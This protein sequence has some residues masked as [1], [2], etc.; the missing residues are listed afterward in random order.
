MQITTIIAKIE[1]RTAQKIIVKKNTV[2][3]SKSKKQKNSIIINPTSSI[4]NKG[5][6]IL[7]Q[8]TTYPKSCPPNHLSPSNQNNLPQKDT[9]AF[10]TKWNLS[11][12]AQVVL[13]S[14]TEEE[15]SYIR[16]NF[17]PIKLK[18]IS[19]KLTRYSWKVKHLPRPLDAPIPAV[20]KTSFQCTPPPPYPQ[21]PKPPTPATRRGI[22]NYKNSCYF[23]SIIQM[24][25]DTPLGHAFKRCA[26]YYNTQKSLGDLH[27]RYSAW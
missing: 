1:V 25:V 16:R 22:K 9:D 7:P 20:P 17:A 21:P 15:Q 8:P 14:C 10:I 3:D 4:K 24:L 11:P 19:S 2:T 13:K 18:Q 26:A 23:V 27:H 6:K 5:T 12:R